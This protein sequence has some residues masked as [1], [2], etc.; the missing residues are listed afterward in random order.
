MVKTAELT[1]GCFG[2]ALLLDLHTVMSNPFVNGT[3]THSAH[4]HVYLRFSL[5]AQQSFSCYEKKKHY[6]KL[7]MKS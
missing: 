6:I 3:V 5:I 7:L 4:D 1:F 2:T